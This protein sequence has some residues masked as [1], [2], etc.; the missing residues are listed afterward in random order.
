MAD[1]R[2]PGRDRSLQVPCHLTNQEVQNQEVLQSQ[3]SSSRGFSSVAIPIQAV[4]APMEVAVIWLSQAHSQI[5]A[6]DCWGFWTL[7]CR[8]RRCWRWHC[9][10]ALR[11]KVQ[12]THR[13]RNVRLPLSQD[14]GSMIFLLIANFTREKMGFLVSCLPDL[15]HA[16]HVFPLLHSE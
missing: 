2:P 6:E 3:Q 14:Y 9:A 10:K 15:M 4:E 7:N 11:S 16:Q 8:R 1:C 5:L 12:A 13:G